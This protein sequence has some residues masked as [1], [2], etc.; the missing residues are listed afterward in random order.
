MR[1]VTRDV[2]G[3]LSDVTGPGGASSSLLVGYEFSLFF[4]CRLV[5]RDAVLDSVL[6]LGLGTRSL[7]S[8]RGVRI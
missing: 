1:R 8:G 6:R 5:T 4:P 3:E 2:D 7:T